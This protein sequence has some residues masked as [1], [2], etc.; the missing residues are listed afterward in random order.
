M[1]KPRDKHGNDFMF[2]CGW[3]AINLLAAKYGNTE[4]QEKHSLKMRRL[5]E[6]LYSVVM[7]HWTEW[8]KQDE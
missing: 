5:T 1:P 6:D 8:E 2:A 4:E 3:V 7:K